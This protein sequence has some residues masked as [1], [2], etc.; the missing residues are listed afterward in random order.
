MQ[1]S[2]RVH[3]ALMVFFLALILAL[4]GCS[5][6]NT[7]TIDEP[8]SGTDLS[9]DEPTNNA[10]IDD[11]CPVGALYDSDED[12]CYIDCDGL[13]DDQCDDLDQ[14]TFGEF[15][16]YIDDDFEGAG[17]NNSLDSEQ[18]T[19]I[20]IYNVEPELALSN[21]ENQ[22]PENDNEFRKIWDSVKA[23]LPQ[24]ALS[25][26]LSEFQI[27]TDGQDG[28]LAFVETDENQIGRWIMSFDN[29]DYINGRDAD[30]IHTTVH[31]YGH[32]FFLGA[33][34]VDISQLGDCPNYSIAE[35]CS[36]SDSF[37]NV[38]YQQFWTDIID[39]HAATVG[40]EE[41]EDAIA[42]FYDKYE[43]QFVSE[44]S[45]TNPVEDAAE[46]FTRFILS[47][48]PSAGGP[49]SQQ[50]ILL[51]Y[52]FDELVKMRGTIRAKLNALR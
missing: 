35:G 14:A 16:E 49:I 27:N 38:F 19:L 5:N 48:K 31:E 12:V 24:N 37:I 39:E 40:P 44:Y 20:A 42:V 50:K 47:R 1:P 29:A 30:F 52:Q 21:I 22:Q 41:D 10:S 32:I 26:T 7:S 34:Q 11:I 33:G 3:C 51:F 28:T 8:F 46:I 43:D 23:L 2:Q 17:P 4:S 18:N 45:A 15:D 6:S 36:E 25:Q 9:G 13:T